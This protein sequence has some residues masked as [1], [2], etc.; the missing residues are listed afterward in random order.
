MPLQRE[1]TSRIALDTEVKQARNAYGMRHEKN[2]RS[3]WVGRA[4]TTRVQ[5]TDGG[6]DTSGFALQ[7]F[8]VFGSTTGVCLLASEQLLEIKGEFPKRAL[9]IIVQSIFVHAGCVQVTKFLKQ[10]FIISRLERGSVLR[11]FILKDVADDLLVLL[12]ELVEC[13]EASLISR[14]RV[15]LAPTASF[16]TH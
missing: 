12:E 7:V 2:G 5:E 9:S 15:R 13:G 4:R 8:I 11:V 1:L 10:F 3:S 16:A 6:S 14:E